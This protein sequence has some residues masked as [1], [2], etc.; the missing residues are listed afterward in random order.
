MPLP[1][2]ENFSYR[3]SMLN[4]LMSRVTAA[5]YESRGLT[6]HQWKVLS[7]L[8]NYAPMSAAEVTERVTLDKAAVSRAVRQLQDAGLIKRSLQRTDARKVDITMTAKGRSTYAAMASEML[9]LQENLFE[10]LTKNEVQTI[11]SALDKLEVTLRE[12]G[13]RNS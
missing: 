2:N 5:I 6:V 4:F 1:L 11:F 9:D 7:V 8:F 10:S 3:L 13:D 12:H